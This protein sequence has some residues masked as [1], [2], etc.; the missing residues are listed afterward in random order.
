MCNLRDLGVVNFLKNIVKINF[1]N[2]LIFKI[3]WRLRKQILS[4]ND[5]FK[6]KFNNSYTLTC[7]F[8][9]VNNTP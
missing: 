5:E 3:S 4:A 7:E 1:E 6:P 8:L 2:L 9:L